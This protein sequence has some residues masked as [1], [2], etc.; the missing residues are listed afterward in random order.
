MGAVRIVVLRS[1]QPTAEAGV[2][3]TAIAG[4][5]SEDGLVW[6]VVRVGVILVFACGES[7]RPDRH[8]PGG[9]DLRAVQGPGCRMTGILVVVGRSPA[10]TRRS[11]FSIPHMEMKKISILKIY[12][13]TPRFRIAEM[14]FCKKMVVN[15]T[16]T[17]LTEL[18]FPD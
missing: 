13:S 15:G 2:P 5:P 14:S 6:L 9:W 1:W 8:A 10:T 4:R 7:L 3:L 12:G 16:F 18:I 17:K 11:G